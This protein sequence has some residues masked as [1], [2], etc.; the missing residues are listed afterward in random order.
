MIVECAVYEEGRRRPGELELDQ[1]CEA[2]Q[3]DGAVVWIDLYEP[4]PP[5][6]RAIREELS[7]HPLAIEDALEAHQRPKVERYGDQ[8]FIVLKSA[9]YVDETEDVVF[10]EVM[11]FAGEGFV[12][13]VRHGDAP[14]LARVRQ[15]VEGEPDRLRHGPASIV[16]A[17]LDQ[18]VDDYEPVVEGLQQDIDEVEEGLFSTAGSS[19]QRIYSLGREVLEFSRAVQPLVDPIRDVVDGDVLAIP[20]ELRTY[21]RDVE[22]HIERVNGRVAAQHEL[23]SNLLQ[24]NLTQVTIRQNEDMR[25]ISAWVAIAAVPTMIAGIYGMNFEHMPEL[26][27]RVGYPMALT[28]MA[29]VCLF[30]FTRFK[31]AGWL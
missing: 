9:R 12:I 5:E 16:H 13:T 18:V 29:T 23:L 10:G 11:L 21:F 17:V 6:F 27:W 30:L 20:E 14:E 3:G 7:L 2:G 19:T 15:D 28:V 8:V 1:A 31:R 22:D 4:T 26:G 25:K 24:A